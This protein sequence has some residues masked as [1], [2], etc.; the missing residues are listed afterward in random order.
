MTDQLCRCFKQTEV[1]L[2]R[3]EFKF[4][5]DFQNLSI[6]DTLEPVY[7]TIDDVRGFTVPTKRNYTLIRPL[8]RTSTEI[9]TQDG[10][11]HPSVFTIIY[12]KASKLDGKPMKFTAIFGRYYCTVRRVISGSEQ[13]ELLDYIVAH[14]PGMFK[15]MSPTDEQLRV[16]KEATPHPYNTESREA[17]MV[18]IFLIAMTWGGKKLFAEIHQKVPEEYVVGEEE[19]LREQEL[20]LSQ[21]DRRDDR[22]DQ[23]MVRI[24]APHD[25]VFRPR[26]RHGGVLGG[27]ALQR[28]E[29]QG[30]E[31]I[32]GREEVHGGRETTGRSVQMDLPTRPARHTSLLDL[33]S[34]L[35]SPSL[36]D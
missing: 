11:R 5:V 32:H 25:N 36:L 35:D 9:T 18:G 16:L 19:T 23:D 3:T 14:V 15:L 33:P 22:K 13:L 6:A 4:V 21:D 12:N 1:N 10:I 29:F 2:E 27:N 17:F 30:R 8:P 26:S 20:L 31:G 24:G 34:L 28:E 7:I